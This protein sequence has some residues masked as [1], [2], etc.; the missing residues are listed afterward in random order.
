MTV[1]LPDHLDL[2]ATAPA[3]IQKLRGLILKLAI[4]G[5]L[6][7]TSSRSSWKQLTLGDVGEWGSGGTPLKAHS[8]YY[9][10]DTPWLVIGDLNEGVVTS[11]ETTITSKGLENS[12]AKLVP[13]GTVLIAMYG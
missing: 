7:D 11:A 2:I 10:G 9:G 8:D 13:V 3:G 6:L 5:Q 1:S 12:S 4:E